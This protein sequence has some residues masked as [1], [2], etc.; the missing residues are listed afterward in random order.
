MNFTAQLIAGFLN[1]NVE[2]DPEIPVSNISKIEEGE[3]G[4]LSFLANP[5][6]EKYIYTTRASIVIVNRDFKPSAPVSATLIR[7]DN[8]YEA[9]ARL[10]K[11]VENQKPVRSG[12][13]ALASVSAGAVIGDRTWIA[14]FAVVS[15]GAKIGDGVM[16]HPQVFIGEKVTVGKN[17]VLHS[18]VKIY[19]GCVIGENCILHAGTV[20]GSDGF[21]F[22]PQADGSFEK[23]PQ[24]GNVLIEDEVEI[25]SNCTIDRATMGSTLIRKGAKLD[26]LIQVAHNVEIGENTVIAAQAGISGSTRIGK[27]V[28]IGGQAGLVGHI[29]IADRVRI[30]A[31]AGVS[32]AILKEGEAVQGSP[33]FEY[34]KS[35]K[36]YVLFK[37]L[38]ELSNQINRLER[39]LN[40]LRLYIGRHPD[41]M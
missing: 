38:P 3:P 13:S 7:V 14:D 34:M 27:N 2:G 8:A 5:K 35:Q 25:G 28:M 39:H 41:E 12:I 37:N 36:S 26:N 32:R 17:T 23:I 19:D 18:G 16:I 21:G 31:Q 20:V 10:M 40:E 9:F 30:Q 22:A 33:A 11:L 24:L 29:R 1:G 15:E 4:T 6:Y